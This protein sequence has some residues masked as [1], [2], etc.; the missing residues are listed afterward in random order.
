MTEKIGR[1]Y[2]HD[3]GKQMIHFI[4]IFDNFIYL[5]L[6]ALGLFAAWAVL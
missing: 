1:H 4:C 6:V 3:Y 5:F 2:A